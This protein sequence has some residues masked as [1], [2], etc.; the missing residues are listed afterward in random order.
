MKIFW[1]LLI[2]FMIHEVKRKVKEGFLLSLGLILSKFF[3]LNQKPEKFMSKKLLVLLVIF[4]ALAAQ[5]HEKIELGLGAG[6]THEAGGEAFN[7][8]A[9]SG[10]GHNFW[11][12]Y[13]L[14]DNWGVELGLDKLDFDGIDSKHQLISMGAVYRW[15]PGAF[16]HPLAKI[17]VAT[18]ESTSALDVKTNSLAA[19]GAAGLEAEWKYI[20][21][22]VLANVYHIVKSDDAANL[23]G[24]QAVQPSLFITFHTALDAAEEEKETSVSQA[25]AVTPAKPAEDTD[26]D[27][28]ADG[29]DKCPN[30]PAGVAVNQ[31]GCSEKEKASVRLKVNF[32]SNKS[33]LQSMY[34]AEVNNLADFMKKFPETKVEIAGHT[35]SL[36]DADR[37]K[38][39]SQKRA[40]SV[41]A[42][43]VAAGVEEAR[44]TAVGY[45]STQPVADNKT[46]A[47]RDQ[48]RRVT[49]EISI[50]VDKKK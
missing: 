1:I 18:A 32:L 12:G 6:N 22:G 13:G 23:K 26:K 50:D 17:A 46:K 16:I 24:T 38:E 34:F 4:V 29:D 40:E 41:K 39:L 8:A 48:N 20:S 45:G 27:G 21:A 28:I 11:L 42:A 30:T 14:D 5:A 49:A 35:D 44:L 10:D 47:G 15:M 19:K 31:I 2:C 36:G 43:L 37:N 33:D 9:S 25:P 7:S 3:Q